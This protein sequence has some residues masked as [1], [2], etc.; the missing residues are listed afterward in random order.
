M[1]GISAQGMVF[2]HTAQRALLPH[3]EWNVGR[4]LGGP[5]SP[6]WTPTR[7]GQFRTEFL[8]QGDSRCG[9]DITAELMGWKSLRF[10]VS[11]EP[12]GG[13]EGYRWAYTP[14]LGLFQG[15]IDS[16]GNVVVNEFRVRA[17]LESVSTN[18]ID[19]QRE[20]RTLIGLP[21]D[22]ELEIY[23]EHGADAPVIWLKSIAN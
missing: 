9:A 6:I 1:N 21:W 12:S 17:V 14:K 2:I 5:I 7:S 3:L 10:E 13:N 18:A 16:A 8:W 23:R 11:Q 22:D 20:M 19:L 15:Q 4:L